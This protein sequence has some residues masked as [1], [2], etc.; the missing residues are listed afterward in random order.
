MVYKW[1]AGAFQCYVFGRGYGFGLLMISYYLSFEIPLIHNMIS[2]IGH[3]IY[4]H[5]FQDK[6]KIKITEK[7]YN[8]L[9]H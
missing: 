2:S 7:K 8:N 9:F 3:I 4:S 6:K 1:T 5:P